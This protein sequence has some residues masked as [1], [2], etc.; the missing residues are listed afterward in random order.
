MRILSIVTEQIWLICAIRSSIT[1]ELPDNIPY[2]MKCCLM[3]DFKDEWAQFAN[4]CRENVYGRM[5]NTLKELIEKHFSKYT[6]LKTVIMY[7][8][9][10]FYFPSLYAHMY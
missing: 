10:S 9:R 7:A 6:Y 3:A 2:E 8:S 1:R 4:T 5:G